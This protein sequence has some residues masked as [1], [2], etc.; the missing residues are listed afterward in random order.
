MTCVWVIVGI[1]W[2]FSDKILIALGQDKII[3]INA[4][5]FL[6]CQY[7]GL[8]FAFTFQAQ[9]SLI[10]SMKTTLPILISNAFGCALMAVL[11]TVLVDHSSLE[12]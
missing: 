3:S 6:M 5:W 8:L 9:K 10:G 1:I 12:F 7:P 11:G 2:S 4:K